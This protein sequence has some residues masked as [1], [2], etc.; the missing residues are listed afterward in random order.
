MRSEIVEQLHDGH[1]GIMKCRECAKQSV[2]WPGIGKAL[3][4]WIEHCK[5]CQMAKPAQNRESLMTTPLPG[6]PWE[7]VAADICEVDKRNYLVV[8]DYFSRYIELAYLL[9]MTGDTVRSRLSAI[10]ARWGCPSVLVTDN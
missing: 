5:H 9:H 6:R 10:F 1:M 3:Q 4:K 8:V 2:W 7:R